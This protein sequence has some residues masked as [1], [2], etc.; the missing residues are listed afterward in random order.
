MKVQLRGLK[1]ILKNLRGLKKI[2]KILRGLK[3]FYYIRKNAPSGYTAEKMTGPL[4]Q[5]MMIG[6]FQG[7]HE[8]VSSDPVTS[9]FH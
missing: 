1:K 3:K 4:V 8:N 2:L 5:S 7:H 9:R 6:M